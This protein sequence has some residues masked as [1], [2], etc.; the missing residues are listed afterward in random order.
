M[1]TPKFA[2]IVKLVY[3]TLGLFTYIYRD[4]QKW[5]CFP[6]GDPSIQTSCSLRG[7]VEYTP[8]GLDSYWS[9]VSNVELFKWWI[10]PYCQSTFFWK[11]INNVSMYLLTSCAKTDSQIYVVHHK[12]RHISMELLHSPSW[13]QVKVLTLCCWNPSNNCFMTV[14]FLQ[15]DMDCI[16]TVLSITNYIYLK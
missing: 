13:W 4:F 12:T 16:N 14:L 15:Y 3:Y 7:R 9:M 8:P 10:A 6:V 2:A 1:L 11:H 5:M